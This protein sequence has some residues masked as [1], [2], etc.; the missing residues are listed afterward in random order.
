MYAHR[1]SSGW[2]IIIYFTH[3]LNYVDDHVG[4]LL[5]QEGDTPGKDIHVVW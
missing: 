3:F 2:V 4:H 1:R 5:S